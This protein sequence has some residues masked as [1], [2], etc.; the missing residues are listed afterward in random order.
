[1]RGKPVAL[2]A[3]EFALLAACSNG[4]AP[5][6]RG[7]NSGKALRLDEEVGSNAIEVHLSALRLKL[8]PDHDPQRVRGVWAGRW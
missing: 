7:R 4:R 3:R 5:R 6:C 2:S 8:P 1:V